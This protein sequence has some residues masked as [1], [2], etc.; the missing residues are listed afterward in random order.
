METLLAEHIDWLA[1]C[2]IGLVSHQAA[3]D[4][5]GLTSAERLWHDPRIRLTALFGPEH[6]F[7]GRAGAG[8]LMGDDHHPEWSIPIF[9]LYGETRKPTPGMLEKVDILIVEFQ[10]LGARPYTYVSTLRLL[11]EAAAEAGKTVIVADRPVP[12]P[13]AADGPMLDPAF[14]SFVGLVP[15]PMQ[16]GMT[17]AE[18]ASWLT[19]ALALPLDLRIAPMRHYFREPVRQAAWPAWVPPSPR[20]RSWEAACLFTATVCGEAL[21]ALDYGSGGDLSF[22]VMG[23]PW[24]EAS[25]LIDLLNAEELPG[26]TF[27]PV[28]Y[29]SRS[30]RHEGTD[31]DGLRIR[32]SDYTAFRPV[33][34]GI[35]ILD[36]IQRLFGG[37]RLWSAPGT[38]PE[39][40]D[41]LFGTDRVRR[42]LQAGTDW[43][44]IC[45]TWAADNA[46]FHHTRT[47]CL[48]YPKA[49]AS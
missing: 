34:T 6:G 18:T 5:S 30:G 37:E 29:R 23:A 4:G 32:V 21:P 20:I 2:R 22:Q 25:R 14:E 49:D 31:L 42:A 17:P 39:W 36:G 44:E 13:G 45:G 46:A 3:V 1:G 15:A 41:K 33:T 11:L 16:Y 8:E 9:S 7:A 38:R 27:E 47:A 24:L 28:R 35:L 26:A 12:C 19:G 40:F 48:L 43:R 10:D